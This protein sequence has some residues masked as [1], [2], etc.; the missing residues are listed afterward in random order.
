MGV[1]RELIGDVW[2]GTGGRRL[3]LTDLRGRVVLL[4]FWT[5]CCV[6]CH[7]VLAELRPIEAK[8]ADVL[9]V[10]GVHSPKFEHEK[11]PAAVQAAMQRHDITHA[12][13]NDPAMST[14]QAYGVRAWPTLVLL[15]TQGEVV[16][17]FSGEGHAHAI[18]ARIAE[19]V[20]EAERS[21]TLRRG[22]DVFVAPT[23]PSTPYR[24]PG[25]AL[26][27]RDGRLVVSESGGHRLA[28]CDVDTPNEPLFYVGT[29]ER[30]LADGPDP[31]FN[32]PYGLTQ[33]P[34][35]VA[36]Q[37]G[38][39]VVIADTANHA[40]RGWRLSDNSVVTVAGTSE[41][42]MR[43]DATDGVAT[44]VPLSSPWDVT[45]HH[46]AVLIAMAGDHRIWRFDPVRGSVEVV[47]G[48]TN[49][50]LVDGPLS[51]AWFAQTSGIASVGDVVWCLDA[52]TSALREMSHDSINTHVG[53]GLF[54]F[55]HVDGN[56]RDA[57]LQHPLGL[58]ITTDGRIL[59]ADSYN[60]SVRVY[61]PTTGQVE[62][63]LR[64]LAEPSDVAIDPSGESVFVVEA[65][66]GRVSRHPLA[67]SS[68]VTGDALRTMRPALEVGSG[69]V[70]VVVVFE[71][72]PG[73]KRD[74]RYGPA[75]QLVVSAS[76]PELLLSGAGTDTDLTRRVVINPD[77]ADGVLHVS[78]RGASCDVP[79]DEQPYP[80]CRI[81]QQDWGV[82]VKI[83]PNGETTVVLP[84]AT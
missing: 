17:E 35:D 43:G 19:L 18:D 72:P 74:D 27:L 42:W 30:G 60:N 25:K 24:Q 4:D 11:D 55:G 31:R 41:Q 78:A 56:A 76:P 2:L 47:A 59:I 63:L 81:H 71:P 6:N 9:T 77:V 66:A 57:L 75:T 7:H 51:Q 29:G 53:R 65:S 39:D 12:V 34:A 36:S 52:E 28:V 69:E 40:L 54:D 61:Q 50:G 58:D 8:Y 20:E 67:A 3:S 37:V 70:D 38:Y 10:V 44:Q 49:E 23:D 22:Q 46:S 33:L 45:W 68:V 84:L 82:P 83:T 64:D 62:T 14:W 1:S 32:E 80:A 5:L 26:V 15:D 13:L 73:E 16:A 79:S 21:G 48:T